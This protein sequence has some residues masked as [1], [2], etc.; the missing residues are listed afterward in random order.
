MILAAGFGT[1]LLPHTLVKP[2]P[3]FPILNQPLLLLLIKRLRS[4]GFDHIIVNCHHL[5]DQ[6][7]KLLAEEPLVTVQEEE[8]ILGTGGGLRGVLSSLR[9]EP[10]LVTNG[11]IYHTINQKQLYDVHLTQ[12][13]KVTMV[14]HDY[15]RFNTVQ[16]DGDRVTGFES[17][18]RENNVAYTGI[19]VIDPEILDNIR[20]GVC[21]CIVEYYRT[22]LRKNVI[23]KSY[24]AEDCFW[25]DMGTPDDF[26]KLHEGLLCGTIPKWKELGIELDGQLISPAAKIHPTAMLR[27]WCSI[28]KA[29]IEDNVYIENSVVWDG[30]TVPGGSKL[31]NRI[32]SSNSDLVQ[33]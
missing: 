15:P 26:L 25:T 29:N 31:I 18:S 22:L 5:S 12:S 10:L 3:L 30:V 8:E 23:I 17:F 24:K 28:G 21:S 6:I 14:T 19:Q 9:D 4:L 2:K 16:V 7:V 13:H 32:I 1:R 11:D 33:P 20:E 27:G